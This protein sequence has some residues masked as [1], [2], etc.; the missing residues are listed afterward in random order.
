MR[1]RQG[2]LGTDS[3]EPAWA[4]ALDGDE[5]VMRTRDPTGGATCDPELLLRDLQ[6]VALNARYDAVMPR[7]CA[8][9]SDREAGRDS[10]KHHQHVLSKKHARIMH[11]RLVVTRA[12]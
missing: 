11:A 8:G 1:E 2:Y 3:L 7:R 9:S 5:P 4:G 10:R 12:E 6:A